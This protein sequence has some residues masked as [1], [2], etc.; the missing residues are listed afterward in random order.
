MAQN[1]QMFPVGIPLHSISRREP[2]L[3]RHNQVGLVKWFAWAGLEVRSRF[4]GRLFTLSDFRSD[5]IFILLS[6]NNF[7]SVSSLASLP[8]SSR[9]HGTTT[10]KII[11]LCAAFV[12]LYIYINQKVYI[13]CISKKTKVLCY[14]VVSQ[15]RICRPPPSARSGHL[16]IKDAQCA[17]KNDVPKNSTFF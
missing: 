9:C 13:T 5:A 12:F 7:P 11:S 1:Q 4:S 3:S 15:L 16:D 10:R 2:I 8:F 17:K 14:S 6:S